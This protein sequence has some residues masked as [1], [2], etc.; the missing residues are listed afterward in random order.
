MMTM[1]VISVFLRRGAIACAAALTLLIV[2]PI[3]FGPSATAALAQGVSIS[4]EFRVALEPYGQFRRHSRWGEVWVP[5]HVARDW[6]PRSELDVFFDELMAFG[7]D[8]DG[9][10][11]VPQKL[12][13]LFP[14]R[15]NG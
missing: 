8:P 6:R 9:N 2:F 13:K 11:I 1:R 14:G 3:A 12:A 7:P 15:S 5:A 10:E 4:S